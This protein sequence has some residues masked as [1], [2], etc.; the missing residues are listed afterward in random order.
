MRRRQYE[1]AEH[2][3][4]APIFG[5]GP[6]LENL[7]TIYSHVN[8]IRLIVIGL[9]LCCAAATNSY[10]VKNSLEVIDDRG[11][12][13]PISSPFKRVL[14]LSPVSTELVY[15]IGEG[16]RLV[17]RTSSC[18]YPIEALS[19]PSVG[20]LFPPDY[21]K[22]IATKPDLILMS[23]G[24][25]KTRERLESF[26]LSVF[27]LKPRD[28]AGI[29]DAMRR[30]GRLLRVAKNADT[31][32][33][34]LEAAV[35]RV[36]VSPTVRPTVLY[37]VWATPLTTAGSNT[38]LADIIHLSGGRNLVESSTEDWPKLSIEW[39]ITANPDIILTG[40]S[41]SYNL[42]TKGKRPAWRGTEAILKKNVFLV[43]NED[44]FVRPG[45]RVVSAIQWLSATLVHARRE[46]K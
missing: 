19:I 16:G 25:I 33:N 18:D 11:V 30:L 22:I 8:C 44:V 26:G 5:Q 6:F 14:S 12:S 28:V 40:R 42:W 13:H 20:S 38:F 32:A 34:L 24:N 36:Q 4:Q 37:E 35:K 2:E 41:D 1:E 39:A 9:A 10:A 45:P 31:A 23:D 7:Q 21:E 17:G 15:A 27:V 29:S 43:P 3:T 46:Q